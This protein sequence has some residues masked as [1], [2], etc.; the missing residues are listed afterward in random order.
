MDFF[1]FLVTDS[2]SWDPHYHQNFF[3]TQGGFLWGLIGAAVIGIVSALI[4][5]FGCCNNK[6]AAKNATLGMWSVFLI[7]AGVVSYFYADLV[8]IGSPGTTDNASIFRR[9][10]F[11][12]ANDDFFIVQT[13]QGNASPTYIQQLTQT[14]NKI[15]SDLDKGGDVRFDFDITTAFLSILVFFLTS[16]CV[17]RLTLHGRAIPMLK[18]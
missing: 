15:K 6:Y 10:S 8:L 9:Y 12:K 4:F 16:L 7:L 14:K 3:V 5:Y 18:P 17:K 11:Y 13:S 1:Y 2:Q